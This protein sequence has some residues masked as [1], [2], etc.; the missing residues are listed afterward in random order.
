VLTLPEIH[1]CAAD[2]VLGTGQI[3]QLHAGRIEIDDTPIDIE[4]LHAVAAPL[5][6]MTAQV[7]EGWLSHNLPTAVRSSDYDVV[8]GGDQAVFIEGFVKR[9]NVRRTDV[10]KKTVSITRDEN[11]G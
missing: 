1:P 6:Q 9:R 3:E 4:D 10:P 7:L 2:Q 8:D 11:Q 5:D